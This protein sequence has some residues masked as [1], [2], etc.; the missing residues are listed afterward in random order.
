MGGATQQPR[1]AAASQD[2]SS[3]ETPTRGGHN[4]TNQEEAAEWHRV[5]GELNRLADKLTKPGEAPPAAKI[6]EVVQNALRV[7]QACGP[8][9]GRAKNQSNMEARLKSLEDKIDTIAVSMKASKGQTW[10][11]VA[12]ASTVR[13]L[14]TAQRTSVKVRI[15][16][17]EGKTPTELLAAVRPTIQGAYA[18]RP[19]KS[20]DIEV[21]VPDQKAKDHALNQQEVEG[22]KIL[23]QDYPVEVPGVP[24]SVTIKDGKGDGNAD[25]IKEICH[26]TRKTVPGIMINRVR[27]LLDDSARAERIR[28]GKTRSTV[29]ISLPTQA[30]QHEVTKRG[31]VIESQVYDARLYNSGLLEKQ[32]FNCQQW[33]HTQS[34]CGRKARCGECAGPHQTRE[35][36]KERVS[37]VNCGR[38]HRSWQKKECRT[39]QKYREEINAKRIDLFAATAR[40]RSMDPTQASLRTD[41]FEFVGRKRAR[42]PTPTTKQPAAKRVG[43]PNGIEAAAK[44]PTQTR[45]QMG[46]SQ[47][48][49][50]Q[51]GDAPESAM[52]VE[53]EGNANGGNDTNSAPY[54]W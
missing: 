3:A 40:I 53:D 10:A 29:I 47:M 5:L 28:N 50:Q 46:S 21:M 24:L 32:C 26:G 43:R 36:P 7:L 48:N 38:A 41:G 14:P 44:D 18:V 8:P 51:A 16:N 25:L 27:W 22:C 52:D 4:A 35:C 49:G 23:R 39:F 42:I 12:A 9:E 54:E 6:Q 30:L 19:L 37:C 11:N 34:A 1:G 20:G 45:I 31:V 13:T 17:T 2:A 33:G 15:A